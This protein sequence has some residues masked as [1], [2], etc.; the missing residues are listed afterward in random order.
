[1]KIFIKLLLLGVILNACQ[2]SKTE[3][4]TT[5]STVAIKEETPAND[6]VCVPGERVGIITATTTLADLEAK[7][8]K[9]VLARDTVYIG[10]G[11]F[12]IGTIL[13]KGTPNELQILWKDTTNFKNPATLMVGRNA[14]ANPTQTQWHTDT[15]IKVGTT[16][17]ELE[18]VNGKAFNFSGFGWDY[19]GSVADWDGG[20]L[21]EADGVSYFTCVLGYNY[22][23]QSLSPLVDKLLGDSMFRSSQAEAQK[24]NPAIINFQIS[25]R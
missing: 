21:M 5:D 9:D 2:N 1:M 8:G 7:F 22:D 4:T 13:Y 11:Y 14:E 23:D 3:D 25:F 19:G 10:E 12:E 15:G 16:L 24:L 6:F 17:K 20:K 18:K